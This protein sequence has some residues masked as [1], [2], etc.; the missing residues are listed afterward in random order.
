M[1]SYRRLAVPGQWNNY[2]LGWARRPEEPEGLAMGFKDKL[3]NKA[4]EAT[5]QAKR[6]QGEATGNDQ[7]RAEGQGQ[8]RKANFKQAGEKA[9]DAFR[10]K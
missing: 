2:L 5:G 9:K 6:K 10:R 8:Q 7:Q 3:K 4:Q 1:P